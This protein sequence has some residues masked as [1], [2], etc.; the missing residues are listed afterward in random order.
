MFY[1]DAAALFMYHLVDIF[2]VD[3]WVKWEPRHD[4]FMW[5]HEMEWN[6]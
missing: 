1:D 2:G 4:E 3:N 5:A 6:V